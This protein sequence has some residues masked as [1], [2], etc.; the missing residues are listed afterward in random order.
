MKPLLTRQLRGMCYFLRYGT[1]R[2]PAPALALNSIASIAARLNL[3]ASDVSKD[4]NEVAES[5]ERGQLITE[6]VTCR[7]KL[8][9]QEH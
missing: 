5:G 6:V 7:D 9:E 1:Y 3:K 4:L 2:L 8:C